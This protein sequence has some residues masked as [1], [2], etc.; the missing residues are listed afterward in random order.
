MDRDAD[1]EIPVPRVADK[2]KAVPK[3]LVLPSEDP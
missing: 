1:K 3:T 2:P